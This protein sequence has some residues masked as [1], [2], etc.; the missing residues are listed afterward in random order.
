MIK[1]SRKIGE[2]GRQGLDN[3]YCYCIEQLGK[4]SNHHFEVKYIIREDLIESRDYYLL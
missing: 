2:Y 4:L 3:R 1:Q